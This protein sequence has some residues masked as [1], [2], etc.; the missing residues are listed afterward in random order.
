MI[1]DAINRI[2]ELGSPNSIERDGKLFVDKDMSVLED[3]EKLANPLE[4]HTLTAIKQY[5]EQKLDQKTLGYGRYIIH[6]ES[7]KEVALYREL[8]KD[9]KRECLLRAIASETRFRFGQFMDLESF[10]INLQANFEITER[11]RDLLQ[12]IGTIVSENG[13]TQSDDG[14]TQRVTA[15]T[16]VALIGKKS[17]PN[18]VELKPYR[19]FSEVEQPESKFVFRLRQNGD[20]VNAAL[21]EADGAKWQIDAIQTIARYF[22]E[23]QKNGEN[24]N[25]AILA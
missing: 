12:L 9:K 13:V 3:P 18:P 22:E 10:N 7:Y 17:V 5:L 21:F 14:I 15:K 19:T 20:G 24:G 8:N 6:V 16:G 23:W 2:L 1:K 11:T 25:I 4:V